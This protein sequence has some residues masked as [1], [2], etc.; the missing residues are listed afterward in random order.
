M[1]PGVLPEDFM[2][3]QEKKKNSHDIFWYTLWATTSW[4][5]SAVTPGLFCP[6]GNLSVPSDS[7]GVQRSVPKGFPH[8][9]FPSSHTKH[10]TSRPFRTH[11]HGGGRLGEAVLGVE[12]VEHALAGTPRVSNPDTPPA[13]ATAQAMPG[14]FPWDPVPGVPQSTW[15]SLEAESVDWKGIQL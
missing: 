11:H 12:E 15:I 4:T 13:N 9:G 6:G 10:L 7:T 5:P 14:E 2:R 8:K 3:A 1:L